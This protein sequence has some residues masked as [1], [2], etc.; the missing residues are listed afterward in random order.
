M[1]ALCKADIP[2]IIDGYASEYQIGYGVLLSAVSCA[3][4]PE[5]CAETAKYIG[6]AFDR[7]DMPKTAGIQ[8]YAPDYGTAYTKQSGMPVPYDMRSAMYRVLNDEDYTA[9]EALWRKTILYPTKAN[10]W[11][12]K[13]SSS[14][15]EN[16][17]C[18]MQDPEHYG[19]I[20]MNIPDAKY[21]A[22]GW[23]T[24]FKQTAWYR[25]ANWE[26]AGW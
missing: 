22:K 3:D 24:E 5:F 18:T 20:S 17:H 16:F 19:G 21:D 9:W 12:T 2:G 6:Q 14:W 11:A 1:D 4:F 8:I 10:I 26:Q 13:Y 7:N 15:Y 25:L 23:N